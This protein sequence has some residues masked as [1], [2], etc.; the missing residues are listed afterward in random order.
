MGCQ[1]QCSGQIDCLR[2]KRCNFASNLFGCE[3]GIHKS[4]PTLRVEEFD[5]S[6]FTEVKIALDNEKKY[7][8]CQTNWVLLLSGDTPPWCNGTK[9][10]KII[11]FPQIRVFQNLLLKI[12]RPRQRYGAR[13]RGFK[14]SHWRITSAFRDFPWLMLPFIIWCL[15]HNLWYCNCSVKTPIAH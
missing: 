15:C 2:V 6:P 3:L 13:P 4:P 14:H 11:K 9:Y 7:T 1:V 12:A 10:F 5:L 8:L